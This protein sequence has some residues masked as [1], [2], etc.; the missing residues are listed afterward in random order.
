[1]CKITFN[2]KLTSIKE[3]AL[4]AKQDKHQWLYQVTEERTVA[5]ADGKNVSL[6]SQLVVTCKIAG[7]GVYTYKYSMKALEIN[8]SIP[9]EIF[10]IDAAKAGYLWDNE[11]KTYLKLKAE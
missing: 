9:K 5:L 2:D 3:V 1:M 7:F 4:K 6:P 8:E 10:D 11:A